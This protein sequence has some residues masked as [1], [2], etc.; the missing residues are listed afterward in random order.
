VGVEAESIK[1]VPTGTTVKM[2]LAK[3]ISQ[4]HIDVKDLESSIWFFILFPI[5][6]LVFWAMWATI[7]SGLLSIYM[8][9]SHFWNIYIHT[10]RIK[11]LEELRN[12][13]TN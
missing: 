13:L 4:T 9:T 12:G 8:I 7:L 1:M 6:T 10:K 11:I 2:S 3:E 5:L